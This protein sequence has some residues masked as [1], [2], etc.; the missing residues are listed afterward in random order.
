MLG[1]ELIDGVVQNEHLVALL[2]VLL[3]NGTAEN[4]VFGVTRQV[5]NRVLVILHSA[6]VFVERDP[7]VW[8]SGRVESKQARKG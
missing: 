3:K 8:L 2:G 7:A 6:D 1:G 5:K 4:G